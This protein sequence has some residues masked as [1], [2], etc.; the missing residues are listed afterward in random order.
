MKTFLDG[1]VTLHAG[2]CLSVVRCLADDSI[3][4]VVTDPPYALTSIIARYS[5]VKS[6]LEQP[7]DKNLDNVNA[8]AFKRL[9]KGF[10]GK[11]WDTGDT[12]FAVEFWAEILR[13]LKPGGHVAA[14]S[15]T[16]SYHRL[17]CAIEDAGF[18]IRDRLAFMYGVGFPKSH[19]IGKNLMA[20]K[21]AVPA[22][23]TCEACGTIWIP[24]TRFQATRNK[25]CS[26][27]MRSP[28]G[29]PEENRDSL[30]IESARDGGVRADARKR[31]LSRRLGQG[32]RRISIAAGVV[33]RCRYRVRT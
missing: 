12:A 3:D 15:G 10:M 6:N 4:A 7:A 14:F 27:G 5:N 19:N 33:E 25:A 1:R 32:V 17:A 24:K 2:D 21:N 23:R 29:Q 26:K 31:E 11:T 20:R 9:A 13:V 22:Q 16:R 8:G 18:E 30:T 28:S